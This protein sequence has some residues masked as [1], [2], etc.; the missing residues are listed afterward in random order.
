ML[1]GYW[2]LQLVSLSFEYLSNVGV[3]VE[4]RVSRNMSYNRNSRLPL[5]RAMMS[6][7]PWPTIVRI[8]L[9]PPLT[10]WPK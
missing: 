8:L 9:V 10:T 3:A 2:A 5:E 7:P 4:S 1:L 6:Q